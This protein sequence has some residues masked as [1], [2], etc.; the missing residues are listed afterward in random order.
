M[1]KCPEYYQLQSGRQFCE[2]ASLEL[3]AWLLPRVSHDCYHCLISAMEHRFRAGLKEGELETDRSAEKFWLER[4]KLVYEA[5]NEEDYSWDSVLEPL[6]AMV[7]AERYEK[8][9]A[10]AEGQIEAGQEQGDEAEADDDFE[11]GEHTCD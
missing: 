2:F 11:I 4:A 1:D 5:D 3:N 10:L 8:N 6:K 7:D 9:R